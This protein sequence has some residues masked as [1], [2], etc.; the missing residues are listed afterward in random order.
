LK[1]SS[2]FEKRNLKFEVGIFELPE[3]VFLAWSAH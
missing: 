3:K 1:L 2:K